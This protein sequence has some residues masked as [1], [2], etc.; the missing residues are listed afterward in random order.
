MNH[1]ELRLNDGFDHTSPGLRD[2]VKELQRELKKEG[3][4]IGDDGLFG[5]DTENVVKQFQR[6]HG[7]DDDGVVGAYTWAALLAQP[8]PPPGSVFPTTYSKSNPSLLQQLTEAN[9]YKPLI[10]A[11]ASQNGFPV[12][13][14]AGIGS[15]ESRWGLALQPVGPGGTGDAVPRRF[16]TRFRNQALPADGGFGRGLMQIDFDAHEFARTGNWK[17]P[18]ENILYG[19]KVLGDNRDFF[20]RREP[21]LTGIKLLQAAVAS[22][23]TGA[24]NV[25]KAIR[26]QRDID[27]YTAGRNYS[28]DT[29]DR[30]GWF[31][32]QGWA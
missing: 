17:D 4:D 24:G 15:R 31:Q 11:A 5:R 30:A 23:N 19:A 14:L 16:P 9:K 7:L 12:S 22:Y 20:I 21:S 2:D 8:A 18:R 25:L 29:L 6:E 3:F 26:D 28:K 13:L 1:P 32:I 27:Y 10:E